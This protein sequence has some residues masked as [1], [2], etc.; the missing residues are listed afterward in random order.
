[1][2]YSAHVAHHHQGPRVFVVEIATVG[3]EN[4]G[5]QCLYTLMFQHE[6]SNIV[7]L[8]NIRFFNSHFDIKFAYM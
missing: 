4:L 1:M 8:P 2:E 3:K 5:Q 6:S 7:S